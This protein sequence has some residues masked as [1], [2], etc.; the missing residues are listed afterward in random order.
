MLQNTVNDAFRAEDHTTF[1]RIDQLL[2]VLGFGG[3]DDYETERRAKDVQDALR[4]SNVTEEQLD[5]LIPTSQRA[6]PMEYLK[7]ELKRCS[8]PFQTKH[9]RDGN[10]LSLVPVDSLQ[11]YVTKRKLL[12]QL[13]PKPTIVVPSDF[14]YEKY[15]AALPVVHCLGHSPSDALLATTLHDG[16]VI[17]EDSPSKP[18]AAVITCLDD[19]YGYIVLPRSADGFYLPS[20]YIYVRDHCMV[21]QKLCPAD[22]TLHIGSIANGYELPCPDTLE[23]A[24][25]YFLNPHKTCM[26]KFKANEAVQQEAI[27]QATFRCK[28]V[29]LSADH[30]NYLLAANSTIPRYPQHIT[31][32]LRVVDAHYKV[33]ECADL[34]AVLPDIVTMLECETPMSLVMSHNK[35]SC[36]LDPKGTGN[37][38][39]YEITDQSPLL[40]H[41]LPFHYIQL[42]SNELLTCS[43]VL[44]VVGRN[45]APA[46][47]ST[48]A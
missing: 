3:L 13:Q 48:A 1:N 5:K 43:P 4:K 2:C 19:G 38:F 24:Y 40:V 25:Y 33:C 41:E 30:R 34:H 9:K 16:I 7:S 20:A 26:L 47:P 8:I 28:N 17:E 37:L 32:H 27:V 29:T 39:T 31:D 45:Y 12:K 46:Q 11:N 23:S 36:Y 21:L 10:Y 22:L 44:H 18:W 14:S 42:T 35:Q 15:L 6:D